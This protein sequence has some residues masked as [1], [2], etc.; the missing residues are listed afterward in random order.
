MKDALSRVTLGA[1]VRRVACTFI[2]IAFTGV[3]LATKSHWSAAQERGMWHLM[4]VMTITAITAA[5]FRGW[6]L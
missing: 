2:G 3:Y 1:R 6:Y 4:L 5:A